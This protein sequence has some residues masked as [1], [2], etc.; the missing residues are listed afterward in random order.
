MRATGMAPSRWLALIA[1]SLAT[2]TIGLD[3]TV[4]TVALPTLAQ[5]LQASTA[6]L[7][8]IASSYTLVL[9]AA[10][11]PAGALG[12]RYGRKKLLLG[13]L[14][15]FGLAS[16]ACAY[17]QSADALI[18]ARAF[19]GL[20]AA[21]MIP[22]SMAVLPVLFADPD[23]R[24]RALAIWVSSMAI[25]L[26]L[27]PVLGGWMLG[28][29]WW[30]SIFLI[31]VPM[32]LL[33]ALA[34]WRFI[35]ES[36][37]DEHRPMDWPGVALSSGGLTALIFGVIRAGE[38][39]WTDGI[40]WIAIGAA[41]V[42]LTA[43][44]GWQRG[45]RGVG[46]SSPLI[47]LSLF[48]SKGFTWGT[49]F[50]T[51]VNF[52]MFGLFF[53]VPQYFQAVLGVDALGSGLRL[54]PLI[55]GLVAGTRVA[56]Q[57]GR[58]VGSGIVMA[59]GFTL[60]TGG[61]IAGA[62]TSAGSG[63]WYIACWITVVGLGMG[64][65]LP[66]SMGVALDELSTERSGSGSALIQAVRQAGGTIGVAVLGTVLSSAYRSGLGE[67]AVPPFSD[68][69]TQGVGAATALGQP[70]L[71][72]TIE[73]AFVHGLSAM[74]LVSAGICAVGVVLALLRMPRHAPGA[75]LQDAQ[76]VHVG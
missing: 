5:D 58:R 10:L 54:L 75:A 28:H 68:G 32:V 22:M 6:Q 55:V 13:A 21:V 45:F 7:Q 74:L 41:A 63:Y 14:L 39:G 35:P 40:A 66:T 16:L 18:G 49:T 4:L 42:L 27:G 44:V 15:L 38:N 46:A 72:P 51:A 12:D 24:K 19:L 62:F 50:A 70:Q 2:L 48:G 3:S 47:D 26:P 17:C 11:L 33:A 30:G 57:I 64:V 1:L 8:W 37:S 76:S 29:F 69:V 60:L 34:V 25:G 36:R 53:A 43:F 20:A 23:E 31:N 73:D 61:L 65:V 9:A 71:I 59:T 52:A 67:L 56:E